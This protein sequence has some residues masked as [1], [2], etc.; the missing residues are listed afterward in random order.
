[1]CILS[2]RQYDIS[3]LF[4]KLS[5]NKTGLCSKVTAKFLCNSG[6]VWEKSYNQL[7]E[8]FLFLMRKIISGRVEDSNLNRTFVYKLYSLFYFQTTYLRLD[9]TFKIF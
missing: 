7:L 2:T 4:G 1:M 8:T 3:L 9:F 6:E 5:W